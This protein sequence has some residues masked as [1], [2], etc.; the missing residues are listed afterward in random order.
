MRVAFSSVRGVLRRAGDGPPYGGSLLVCVLVV[1]I[2]GCERLPGKP[3]EAD[4]YVRPGKVKEFATL[5]GDNCAG[6][7]GDADRPGAAVGL[8]DPVYLAIASDDAIRSAA[9]K[10]VPDTSMPA[11]A[12]S[13]G[14][15]LSDEQLDL[16]VHGLRTR[17]GAVLAP[18]NAPPY[19]A[20]PGDAARGAQVFATY[21]A[22]CHGADGSGGPKGGSVVDGSFLALVSDQGLRT[23]VIVG[24]PKLGMPDW[25]GYADGRAMSADEVADVVAWLIAKRRPFPGQPYAHAE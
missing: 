24:R 10:G 25:R 11:F 1:A 13:E 9:A 21:C 19:A 16:I 8:A 22:S 3:L 20:P 17:S 18:A 23:A 7:H 12:R 6:C 15:S 2:A 4:R 5:Y 14:G